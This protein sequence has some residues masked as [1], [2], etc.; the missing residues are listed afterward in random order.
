MQAEKEQLERSHNE[1]AARLQV[2]PALFILH[3][4]LAVALMTTFLGAWRDVAV[5]EAAGAIF[6]LLG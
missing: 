6:K 2:M 4:H 3:F 1:M 5:Y